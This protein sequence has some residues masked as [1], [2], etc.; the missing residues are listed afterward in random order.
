MTE[1]K[2][3]AQGSA[4]ASLLYFLLIINFSGA[5]LS[6]FGFTINILVY[7]NPIKSTRQR[8]DPRI[9]HQKKKK[10]T[11]LTEKQEVRK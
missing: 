10:V 5:P 7:S 1:L 4:S 11:T 3:E 8:E 9:H 6:D 2:L